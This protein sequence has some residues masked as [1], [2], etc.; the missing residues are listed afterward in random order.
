MTAHT[1]LQ[2]FLF[3][4]EILCAEVI[5]EFLFVIDIFGGLVCL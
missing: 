5:S 3:P 4:E 2:S 1:G